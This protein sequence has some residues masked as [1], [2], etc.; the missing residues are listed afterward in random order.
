ESSSKLTVRVSS[1]K[2]NKE[3]TYVTVSA[4]DKGILSLSSYSSPKPAPYFYGQ[5]RLGIEIR[6]VYADL[7]KTI[8]AHAEYEVGAGDEL[9]ALLSDSVVANKRKIVALM[10]KV[11]KLDAKG[12]ATVEFDIPDF[13]GALQLMA[14]AW[15]RNAVGS[16]TGNVIIKD[17]ISSEMYMPRF[18]AV[19]DR[20]EILLQSSFDTDAKDGEYKFRVHTAGG[21]KVSPTNIS[22]LLKKG[23][24]RIM[25]QKLTLLAD[26]KED[27]TITLDVLHEGKSI[28]KR[29]WEIGVRAAY[30]QSY[31]RKTGIL[32]KN[33]T[34]DISNVAQTSIWL[35]TKA[36]KLKLSGAPLLPTSSMTQELIDYS[37]RCAEQTTSRAMPWLTSKNEEKREIIQKAIERVTS[38]Q[39]IN[40]GIGLW[41][42]SKA[43]TWITAYVVDMLTQARINGYTVPP[44]NINLGLKWLELNL[45]RWSKSQQ[46]QEADAYAL[47]VLAKNNKILHSEI[48]HHTQNIKSSIRSAQAWGHLAASLSML[49]EKEKSKILFEKAERS[50]GNNS[51]GF[52]SNYGGSLRDKASLAILLEKSG[53]RSKAEKLFADLSMDLKDKKYLSTQEMSMLL[54]ANEVIDIPQ[55]KLI[56]DIGGKIHNKDKTLEL[57]ASKLSDIPK[58][59]NHGT[60]A[61]WYNL[62]FIATPDPL[63]YK[64][65][66]N[67]GFSIEKKLYDLYG[68][69]LNI[70]QIKRN[71]RV[72]VVLS[73]QIQDTAI[74]NPLIT[75]W[76]PAGFEIENPTIS[77]LDASDGLKWLGKKSPILHNEYRNDRFESALKLDNN[78]SFIVAYIARA[79]TA[80]DFTFPP[81]KIE[82]MYQPRY[83]AF[84]PFNSQKLL[85]KHRK[86]TNTSVSTATQKEKRTYRI[87]ES[88]DYTK[89][90]SSAIGDL[91]QYPLLQLNYLRNGIF[92]QAGLNFETSNPSL[93]KRFTAFEWYAPSEDRSGTVYRRLTLLQKDN[94]LALL[95]EEKQRCGG[96]VL[97]DFYLT[98]IK[99]LDESY[100]KKYSKQELRILRNSLIARHGLR[101]KDHELTKIFL[102][103]PWYTPTDIT[104]SEILDSK[105]T[106]IERA[107]VRSMLKMERQK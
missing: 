6:D 79:V 53:L 96:L 78:N 33:K 74:L 56:L 31:V 66:E 16:A 84:S 42:S 57:K 44:K 13:Q 106:D 98:K 61:I 88:Q 25:T 100:L 104:V 41:N 47:Y 62:S 10:S 105:M 34:L 97:A 86:D 2:T 82:D 29:V 36:I 103:M 107:N 49:G 19:G 51:K 89:I 4:V 83:R 24:N 52:Y 35:Q 91:S 38:M 70:D 65:E 75:D 101:F 67:R 48:L 64:P 55:S 15:S 71:S 99:Q 11:I 14:V 81:A 1:E 9:E 77:G 43:E 21:I 20:A 27:G 68:N 5:R 7:I 23:N 17:P 3:D 12:T 59:S 45:D 30:P 50:L 73:G 40:G 87:L 8:G 46:K 102:Q 54:R 80:G 39:K 72:V 63:H 93:H 37:G 22:Y 94:V 18:I 58:V 32:A 69:I 85:I 95:K 28:T 90:Y 92:A 76:L 60:A 26:K